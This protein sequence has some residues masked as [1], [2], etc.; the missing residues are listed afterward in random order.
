MLRI[1]NIFTACPSICKFLLSLACNCNNYSDYFYGMIIYIKEM[2][3]LFL[4]L[5]K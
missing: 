5:T 2:I 4:S 1:F 3:K